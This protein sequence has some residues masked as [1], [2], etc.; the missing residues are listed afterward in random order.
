MDIDRSGFDT[1]DQIDAARELVVSTQ[2]G[3]VTLLQRKMRIGFAKAIRIMGELERR[4]VV[5]GANHVGG[6]PVLHQSTPSQMEE[7]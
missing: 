1:E 6:H 3:S 2:F 5:G 7:R 4:G